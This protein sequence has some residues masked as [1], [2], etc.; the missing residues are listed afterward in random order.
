MGQ[1]EDINLTTD[2]KTQAEILRK[3]GFKC[4]YAKADGGRINLS[5]G[6]GRC[7]DPASYVDD[8]NKTRQDLK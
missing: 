1:L 6:S 7:D 4:K 3:M 5:T 8:I 2:K